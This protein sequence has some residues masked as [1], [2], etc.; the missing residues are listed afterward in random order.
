MS[1]KTCTN[2][3]YWCNSFL[4]ACDII[5]QQN[6]PSVPSSE[7]DDILQPS[8]SGPHAWINNCR[9][10]RILPLSLLLYS[11]WTIENVTL[12]QELLSL[13]WQ[14]RLSYRTAHLQ[15]SEVPEFVVN[16]LLIDSLSLNK[17]LDMVE[18]C[19]ANEVVSPLQEGCMS[20]H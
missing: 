13:A 16:F 6:S 14:L 2:R 10:F 19:W 18:K 11:L 1:C 8:D 3:R 5:S 7:T 9:A 15:V 17:L 20:T 4:W 12:Q